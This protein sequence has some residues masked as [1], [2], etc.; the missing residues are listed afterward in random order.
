MNAPDDI[1]TT[2]ARL[3]ALGRAVA[4][5]G[6]TFD[7][8]ARAARD[9]ATRH[10]PGNVRPLWAHFIAATGQPDPDAVEAPPTTVDAPPLPPPCPDC[11]APHTSNRS[12]AAWR[13]DP[14]Q[15]VP[16]DAHDRYKDRVRCE[17]LARVR[18][19]ARR[20][21]EDDKTA[22]NLRT[23]KQA[24]DEARAAFAH[25]EARER[26]DSLPE[27]SRE[28][29]AERELDDLRQ[30]FERAEQEAQE[31]R[32]AYAEACRTLAEN[33][34]AAHAALPPPDPSPRMSDDEADRAIDA[35]ALTRIA[36]ALERIA[37]HFDR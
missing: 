31:A 24:D 13:E 32:T 14:R 33:R 19:A 26:L 25:M 3:Y 2:R 6:E 4:L 23:S 29:L 37:A 20:R 30:R 1:E 21:W 34:A 36:S 18:Y 17:E 5:G 11:G 8:A 16:Y 10:G 12:C 7:D 28:E 9:M 22:E 27:L 35:H 15:H